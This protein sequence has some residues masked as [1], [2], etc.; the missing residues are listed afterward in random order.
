[1]GHLLAAIGASQVNTRRLSG[2]IFVRTYGVLRQ[3]WDYLRNARKS[4]PSDIPLRQDCWHTM[5]ND[6]VRAIM[7]TD[8]AEEKWRRANPTL[9]LEPHKDRR[10]ATQRIPKRNHEDDS[11]R[12]TH[13]TPSSTLTATPD[14]PRRLA[15]LQTRPKKDDSSERRPCLPAVASKGKTARSSAAAT[16]AYSIT[17]GR[18][19]NRGFSPAISPKRL[20]RRCA[21]SRMRRLR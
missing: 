13:T 21:N 4:S 11:S 15:A 16:D 6:S 5:W 1:M 17:I 20:C 2:Y 19:S 10:D 18:R 12:Q 9:P 3:L 14:A 7:W 8:A